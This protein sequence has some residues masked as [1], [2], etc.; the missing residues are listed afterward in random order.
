VRELFLL[1]RLITGGYFLYSGLHHFTNL[2]MLSTEVARRGIPMAPAAVV[3]AGVLLVIGGVSL[4]LGLVPRI[5]IAALVLFLVPVTLIM[6]P[7]WREV[8]AHRMADMIN[9]TKNFGLLGSV[10]MFLAIPE[11]WP[12]S[13]D[14]R[15][16]L[17]W[18]R[19]IHAKV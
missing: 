16:R 19:R 6:H 2:S 4:I 3:I 15:A 8:G 10:L 12:L 1:G 5:G 14:A 13:V 18:P 11:P 7:F 9:F 17:H